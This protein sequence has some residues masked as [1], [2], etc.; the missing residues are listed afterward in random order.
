M[1]PWVAFSHMPAWRKPRTTDTG[2]AAMPRPARLPKLVMAPQA[3]SK[4]LTITFIN[5]DQR[6]LRQGCTLLATYKC[7][8]GQVGGFGLAGE[9]LG[10]HRF[11]GGL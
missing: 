10:R 3:V 7:T 4:S 8:F 2:M 1:Q 5:L 11:A 9:K 6:C